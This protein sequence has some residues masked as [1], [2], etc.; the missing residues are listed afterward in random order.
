MFANS[1]DPD[2]QARLLSEKLSLTP[3]DTMETNR[4]NNTDTHG[5][6]YGTTGLRSEPVNTSVVK[7]ARSY[8]ALEDLEKNGYFP[9]APKPS[10]LGVQR[11]LKDSVVNDMCRAVVKHMVGDVYVSSTGVHGTRKVLNHLYEP[12]LQSVQVCK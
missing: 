3:T 9:A 1:F 5:G 2:L 6:S 7:K 12:V 4:L 10:A 8:H 11:G